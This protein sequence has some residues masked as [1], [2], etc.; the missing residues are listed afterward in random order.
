[1]YLRKEEYVAFTNL[2]KTKEVLKQKSEKIKI[3]L[4]KLKDKKI[5]DIV[6]DVIN[7]FTESNK[8]SNSVT[9]HDLIYFKEFLNRLEALETAEEE[10]SIFTPLNELLICV[11]FNSETYISYIIQ[12][13]KSGMKA[14]QSIP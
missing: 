13:I 3:K 8:E 7:F 6:F 12:K 11:N 9:F 1:M 5:T 10:N 14:L 2:D 4:R